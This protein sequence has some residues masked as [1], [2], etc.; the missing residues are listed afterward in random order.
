MDYKILLPVYNN[1]ILFNNYAYKFIKRNNLQDKCILLIQNDED[2]KKY[3]E[4]VDIKKIRC[5][6]GK[7]RAINFMIDQQ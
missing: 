6:S 3:A 4:F 7:D 2:E 5:P 1:N